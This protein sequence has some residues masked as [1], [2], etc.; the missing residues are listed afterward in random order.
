MAISQGIGQLLCGGAAVY[1]TSSCCLYTHNTT[2]YGG[3]EQK[4]NA[5]GPI[6]WPIIGNGI[7]VL[8]NRPRILQYIHYDMIPRVCWRQRLL[9]TSKGSPLTPLYLCTPTHPHPQ[10]GRTF[11]MWTGLMEPP[12]IM[13]SRPENVHHVLKTNFANYAKG[14]TF[15]QRVRMHG[16]SAPVVKRPTRSLSHT[17]THT[18]SCWR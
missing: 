17:H 6:F 13:T 10:Y 11:C 2:H 18:H 8:R 16:L 12:Y 7:S 3:Y 9:S 5:P 15:H 4:T 14:E 1:T